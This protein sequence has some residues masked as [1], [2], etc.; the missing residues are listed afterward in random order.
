MIVRVPDAG[1]DETALIDHCRT[2]LAGFE[3]P[4]RVVFVGELPVTVGGK[5]QKHRIR[6][7]LNSHFPRRFARPETDHA[8]AR[9]PPEVY[10]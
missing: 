5:L 4:K 10:P 2:R 1:A 6:A 8:L 9:Y 7:L 3:V